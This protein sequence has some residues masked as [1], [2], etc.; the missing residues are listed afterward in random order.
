MK[1]RNVLITLGLAVASFGGMALAMNAQSESKATFAAGETY[2]YAGDDT[3]KDGYST[4]WSDWSQN[5]ITE[6]GASVAYTF[7]VGEQ[8]KFKTAGEGGWGTAIGVGNLRGTALG[9]FDNNL[10]NDNITCKVAGTYDVSIKDGKVYIDLQNPSYATIYIQVQEWN[11]PTVYA[12]DASNASGTL[13]TL[14]AWPGTAVTELTNGVNFHGELGGIG[15][16]TIPYVGNKANT[17][18]VLSNNG[19]DQSADVYLNPNQYYYNNGTSRENLG[20]QAAV[21]F[22]IAQ[23]ISDA[24]SACDIAPAT[25]TTLVAAYDALEDT[26]KSGVDS[27]T[28][29]TWADKT[30]ASSA[31]FTFDKIIAQ[32]RTISSGSGTRTIGIVTN[33]STNVAIVIIVI[34]VITLSSVVAFVFI[35]KRKAQ[36]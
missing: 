29:W 22:N 20:K 28:L 11:N 23:A 31:D 30:K 26:N 21:I 19:D 18:L 24:G 10:D 16:I 4:A 35:R 12:F 2:Y 36:K 34:S 7:V 17:K 6:G 5:T 3:T 13:K 14:G 1:L 33:S 9:Y 27:T 25:A 32:L 8:F 15:K